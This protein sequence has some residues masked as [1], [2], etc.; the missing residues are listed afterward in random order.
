M[1][2]TDRCGRPF[3]SVVPIPATPHISLYQKLNKTR[4]MNTLISDIQPILLTALVGVII[5][6]AR[7][8]NSLKTRVAVLEKTIEDLLKTIESMQKR[9]DSHSRK[10]DEIYDTLN[11]VK[12]SMSDMKVEIVKE[13]GS[14]TASMSSMASDIQGLSRL[15]SFCDTGYRINR[16]PADFK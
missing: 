14:M 3:P 5:A 12:G 10:Q 13:M 1:S 15:L 16:D 6:Y 4:Q 8:V 9:L 2:Q 11:V 7:Y